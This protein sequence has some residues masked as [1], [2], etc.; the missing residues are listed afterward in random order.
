[1]IIHSGDLNASMKGFTTKVRKLWIRQT[2]PDLVFL[3]GVDFRYS[4]C[5]TMEPFQNANVRRYLC[6][7]VLR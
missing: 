5:S 4:R 2:Q 7:I 3:G 1:M 6:V